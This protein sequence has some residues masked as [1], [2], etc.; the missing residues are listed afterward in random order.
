LLGEV[1]YKAGLVEQWG[2]G[3]LRMIKACREQGLPEPEF[4]DNE[5][6][7][8]KVVFRKDALSADQ[9]RQ[10]GL[11]E[12]QIQ[13]VLHVKA[14]GAISNSEYQQL[15]GAEKRTAS[16]DLSDLVNRGILERVGATGRGTRYRLRPDAHYSG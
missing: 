3:T 6:G 13:A 10:L 12:R 2:T 15:T 5:G 16:R 9:L 7:G 8:F 11:S 1:F 14:A 4:V